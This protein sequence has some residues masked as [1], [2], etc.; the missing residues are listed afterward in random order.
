MV[1]E[2]GH[3]HIWD[4][5]GHY[6]LSWHLAHLRHLAWFGKLSQLSVRIYM[7]MYEYVYVCACVYTRGSRWVS[8]S[9]ALDFISGDRVCHKL[10]L[11]VQ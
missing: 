6:F 8:S 10:Q 9:I 4:G 7:F 2:S 11:K 3:E 5:G 1:W